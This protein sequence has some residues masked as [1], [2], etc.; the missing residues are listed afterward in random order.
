MSQ[1][2]Y[3][4]VFDRVWKETRRWGKEQVLVILLAITTLA[5]Q[6]QFHL[7]PKGDWILAVLAT[8]G[9]YV[10]YA[11]V[12]LFYQFVR[13]QQLL[14]AE[15][16]MASHTNEESLCAVIAERDNTLRTFTEKQR[17]TPAEQYHYD[18]A[19][20]TIKQLGLPCVIALRHLKTHGK[21]IFGT[22]GPEIPIGIGRDDL[23]RICN[24]CVA[25]GLVT[26]R[27]NPSQGER[28]F[29]IALTMNAV[30]DDLL[31]GN[32]SPTSELPGE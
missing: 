12:F 23:L 15:L 26:S 13:A 1:K 7:V 22:Y 32:D 10:A 21:L 28:M 17:R 2:Y 14:Y 5:L 3:R 19:K 11:I 6:I 30:L 31:Y 9:P 25:A 20:K 8:V 24:A 4:T 16:R 27:D 29:E 18:T